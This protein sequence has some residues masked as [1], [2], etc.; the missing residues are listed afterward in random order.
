MIV[1]SLHPETNDDDISDAFSDFGNITTLHLNLDRRTGYVK[2][3]ALIEYAR[4]DEAR[5]AVEEGDGM[6]VMERQVKVDWAFKRGSEAAGGGRERE[7]RGGE[8]GGERSRGVIRR[9]Y[10][11]LGKDKD[12]GRD[13]GRDSGRDRDR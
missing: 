7:R 5:R 1:T 3:Y 6:V 10:R 9:D 11:D 4:E 8:G 12:R 13:R 2:G